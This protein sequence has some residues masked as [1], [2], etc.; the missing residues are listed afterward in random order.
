MV[1]EVLPR[2]AQLP[3]IAGCHLLVADESASAVETAEKKV[4]AEKNLIPRWI[5]LVEGWGD[6]DPFMALCRDLVAD[7]AL[8]RR[9]V[10]AGRS[11]SIACRT[12]AIE[13]RRGV[14]T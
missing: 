9:D 2:V 6:V 7:V 8:R 4:R 3:G 13:A 5:V 11:A 14:A 1:D 12:R 10:A